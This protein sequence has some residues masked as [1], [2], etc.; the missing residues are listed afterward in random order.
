M[1][2]LQTPADSTPR[3]SA[4]SASTPIAFLS[5]PEHAVPDVEAKVLGILLKHAATRERGFDMLRDEH[6]A[7]TYHGLVFDAM[8]TLWQKSGKF[9]VVTLTV[10]LRTAGEIDSQGQ[11]RAVLQRLHADAPEADD[12]ADYLTILDDWSRR[13]LIMQAIQSAAVAV[14]DWRN[15]PAAIVETLESGLARL[16]K[17]GGEIDE[18]YDRDQ[19]LDTLYD[20][21][22]NPKPGQ[23]LKT[24]LTLLDET[25]G[26]LYGGDLIAIGGRPGS[27]KTS[28]GTT[29]AHNVGFDQGIPG[30]VVSLEM[31]RRQIWNRE[32]GYLT[33]LGHVAL[34]T[35]K[36]LGNHDRALVADA[37]DRL[38]RSGLYIDSSPYYTM[39]LLR[40]RVRRMVGSHGIRWVVIDYAGKVAPDGKNQQRNEELAAVT[41]A[42][43]MLAK[44]FD[45]PVILLHQLNRESENNANGRPRMS[46]FKGSGAFEEDADCIL[47]CYR[48]EYYGHDTFED[49]VSSHRKGDIMVAKL[50]NG[51]PGICRHAFIGERARWENLAYLD[52][53]D[54]ST[55]R[56]PEPAYRT[57]GTSY[58]PQTEEAF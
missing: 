49:G 39:A 7:D 1:Q 55:F 8:R 16:A 23:I 32:L 52:H 26:G 41:R 20:E 50:R 38:K 35:G 58:T 53:Y 44:E 31:A 45:I 9:N 5:S 14:L 43:K 13:R 28:L 37:I 27:G 17:P 19:M 12:M 2:N 18:V 15:D 51:E 11:T 56:N 40:Q 30:L 10:A 4:S 29:I 6:F 47:L 33:G 22:V 24:G 57:I 21:I 34:Q 46:D 54:A 36:P 42:S 3:K 25:T 48:A